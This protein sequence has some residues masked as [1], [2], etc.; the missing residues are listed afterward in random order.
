[1]NSVFAD[2]SFYIAEVNPTDDFHIAASSFSQTFRGKIVTTEY[3]LIEVGNWLARV[4]DRV[5]FLN[6]MEQLESDLR[7][8]VIATSHELFVQGLNVYRNRPDKN[9]SLTDCISFAVM[10]NEGLS[11][12][13][14]ADHH[15]EQAGFSRLLI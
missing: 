5:L 9:W 4:G 8:I 6:L 1:M 7:T 3:V 13:L 15:F 14:T 10:E 2:T 11:E 12:A